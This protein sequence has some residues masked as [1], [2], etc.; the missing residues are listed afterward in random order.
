MC[1]LGRRA[2]RPVQAGDRS[3]RTR[4]LP[5]RYAVHRHQEKGVPA[6]GPESSIKPIKRRQASASTATATM[7]ADRADPERTLRGGRPW[8]TRPAD[9]QRRMRPRRRRHR[10]RPTPPDPAA[11]ARTNAGPLPDRRPQLPT[12]ARSRRTCLAPAAGRSRTHRLADLRRDH[13]PRRAVVLCQP[14]AR[15]GHAGHR[16]GPALASAPDRARCLDRVPARRGGTARRWSRQPPVRPGARATD[17]RRTAPGWPTGAAA[18]RRCTPRSARW[19]PRIRRSRWHTGAP[20]A[21]CSTA[22]TRSPRSRSTRATPS[23][24]AISSTTRASASR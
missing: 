23:P 15:P 12:P 13:P 8:K 11:A 17:R 24:P 14:D 3:R 16:V 20:S 5:P 2:S 19:P 21:S 7:G 6:G 18:S 22:S 10:R 9:T 1:L 4:Q